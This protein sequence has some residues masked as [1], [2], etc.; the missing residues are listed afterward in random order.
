MEKLKVV[1]FIKL[2]VLILVTKREDFG[3]FVWF[4][5]MKQ[6]SRTLIR[7]FHIDNFFAH[8]TL[9]SMSCNRFFRMIFVKENKKWFYLLD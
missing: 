9:I 2:M 7:F 4:S 5:E 8:F 3:I 6:K 1:S